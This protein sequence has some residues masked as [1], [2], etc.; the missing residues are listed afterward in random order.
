[1]SERQQG[2][3]ARA[4]SCMSVGVESGRTVDASRIS[5]VRRTVYYHMRCKSVNYPGFDQALH[6]HNCVTK[7]PVALPCA[8][9]DGK[10]VACLVVGS[11][12]DAE[13]HD[14]GAKNENLISAQHVFG[15]FAAHRL[16]FGRK[17]P[18]PIWLR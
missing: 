8:F 4:A 11:S 9:S 13:E 2:G 6:E 1:M 10:Y 15:T 16:A 3:N 17:N 7:R 5:D 18:R 14:I 12:G